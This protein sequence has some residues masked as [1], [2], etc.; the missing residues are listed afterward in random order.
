MNND[1]WPK[2]TDSESKN[3][4]I[5]HQKGAAKYVILCYLSVGIYL[6]SFVNDI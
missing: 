6:Q 3:S 5:T 1:S 2:L 4:V